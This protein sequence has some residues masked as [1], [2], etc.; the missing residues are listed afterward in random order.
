MFVSTK[1]FGSPLEAQRAAAEEISSLMVEPASAAGSCWRSPQ[2]QR[3]AGPGPTQQLNHSRRH[4]QTAAVLS[5]AA[6]FNW[7]LPL[8]QKPVMSLP[9]QQLQASHGHVHTASALASEPGTLLNR[10]P[11][12]CKH[13]LAGSAAHSKPRPGGCCWQL[14]LM[15]N[16]T[17]KGLWAP[18][19]HSLFDRKACMACLPRA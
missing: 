14:A 19:R 2:L 5:A 6:E 15:E 10:A 1:A 13:R 16:G 4:T 11:L 3:P 9:L 12:I 17:D 8:Q 7:R 18:Q